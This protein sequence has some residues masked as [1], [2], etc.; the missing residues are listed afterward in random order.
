MSTGRPSRGLLLVQEPDVPTFNLDPAPKVIT[1]D[2]YGTLVQWYEVLRRE[3]AA[4]LA[5]QNRDIAGASAVLDSFSRHSRHL[6][7][8]RPHRLYKDILRTGFRAALTEHGI[9]L[10]EDVVERLATTIPTMGPHPEVPD[11]L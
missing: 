4:V 10:S 8:E 3:I 1:F 2:C 11:A 7:A 6:E 9:P 5:A